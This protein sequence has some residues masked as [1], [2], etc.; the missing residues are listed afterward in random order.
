MNLI[1]RCTAAL[2][3]AAMVL[4]CAGCTDSRTQQTLHGTLDAAQE[5][6]QAHSAA[7]PQTDAPAPDAHTS[8]PAAQQAPAGTVVPMASGG[9]FTHGLHSQTAFSDM[10]LSGMDEDTFRALL[11]QAA[12]TAAAG[13]KAAFHRACWELENAL[14]CIDTDYTILD[15][16][17]SQNSGDEQTAQAVNEAYLLYNTAVD[18]YAATFH[19]L[20][21]D[22]ACLEL[23][24]REFD[25]SD[26]LWFSSY[27]PDG[28]DA[29]LELS[30]REQDLILEYEAEMA[31]RRP[32]AQTLGE[33]YVS[34]VE[35]RKQIAALSGYDS[36]AEYAY[37]NDFSRDYSPDEAQAIWTLAKEQFVP[38]LAEYQE[39]LSRADDLLW[40]SELFDLSPEAITGALLYGAER[41]SPEILASCRYLLDNGLYDIAASPDKL[42]VGY[43]T[44]LPTYR[45]PFIFDCP[46]GGYYDYQTM[47]HE[48]GH[49]TSYYYSGTDMAGASDYDLSELQSQ[50][51]EVMFLTMYDGIF[52]EETGRLMRAMTVSNL[53]SSVVSGAMYDEFQQKVFAEEA[54]TPARVNEIFLAV[55]KSY[56]GRVYSGCETQ[57]MDVVHNFEQPM[58]YISYAVSALPALELF[59]LQQESPEDALDVYLRAAAMSDEEYYLSEALSQTGL[60]NQMLTPDSSIPDAIRASGVLDVG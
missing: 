1:R 49:F 10:E 24:K 53:V 34:L 38:L 22:S 59:A 2:L 17:N 15:I 3:A 57:W 46:Y 6:M 29:E 21:K 5:H 37:E 12:E 7:K 40:D 27:D 60:S 43:T 54:L 11:D 55:Y 48:F 35:V 23:L 13:S 18:L 50:G 33:I 25:D 47:F 16:R 51:M 41:L 9:Y 31:K 8:Q 56:G 44:W 26:I 14:R 52:G 28:A 45:A 4:V 42:S 36:Y 39:G 32:S 30:T 58:Y 19:T 20:T